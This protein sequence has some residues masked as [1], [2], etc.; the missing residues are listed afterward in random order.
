MWLLKKPK[1]TW[2]NKILRQNGGSQLKNSGSQLK[3]GGFQLK[4]G[5]SQSYDVAEVYDGKSQNYDVAEVYDVAESLSVL[6]CHLLTHY[7]HFTACLRSKWDSICLRSKWS[8]CLR[9]KWD[10]AFLRS[11]WDQVTETK[12]NLLEHQFVWGGSCF[13]QETIRSR[14]CSF[15]I[16]PLFFK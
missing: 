13:D 11:E 7:L 9:S 14:S 3:N 10:S 15:I 16:D 8:V 5:E 1:T 2:S 6:C 4:N 12:S